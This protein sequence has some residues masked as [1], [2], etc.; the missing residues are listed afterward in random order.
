MQSIFELD[1]N[2]DPSVRAVRNRT[3]IVTIYKLKVTYFAEFWVL[4]Y[5]FKPY[6]QEATHIL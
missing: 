6:P 2:A 5:N 3:S 4:S 1:L